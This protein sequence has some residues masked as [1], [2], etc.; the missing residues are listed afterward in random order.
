MRFTRHLVVS[1]DIASFHGAITG[2]A[3]KQTHIQSQSV[4]ASAS[5]VLKCTIFCCCLRRRYCC[6]VLQ[7]VVLT[8]LT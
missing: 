7:F 8:I 2:A 1:V 6:R 5:S 3:S 4:Q